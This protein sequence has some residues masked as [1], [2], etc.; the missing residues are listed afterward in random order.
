MQAPV[1]PSVRRVADQ[2]RSA[3]Y[4]QA[5]TVADDGSV[6]LTVMAGREATGEPSASTSPLQ[7]VIEPTCNVTSRATTGFPSGW[8]L[9]NL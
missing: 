4:L 8:D 3:E 5:G 6:G 9:R 1:L 2:R 7:K